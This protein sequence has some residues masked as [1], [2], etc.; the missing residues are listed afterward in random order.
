MRLA[1]AAASA[2][3]AASLAAPA[4]AGEGYWASILADMVSGPARTSEFRWQGRLASGRTFEIKGVNGSIQVAPGSGDQVELVATRRGRRNDPED[5]RIVAVEH[6]GGMTVCAVY[7]SSDGG[8]P[9]ECAP[10]DGGRMNVK[11]NDVNVDFTVKVPRGVEVVAR[12]VNGA[13]E[14]AGLT[15]DVDAETVNGSVRIETTGVARAETVNGSVN[16][17]M[18]RADWESDLEFKTVN[19]SIRVT[20]PASASTTVDAE[21]VNGSIETDFAVA[22]GKFAKRHLTGTIGSGGR[23]LTLE[24]VNGSITI[25]SR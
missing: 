17:V 23:G 2:V 22:G 12:T 18:G 15:A 7:P 24:T 14:A 11:N 5:V 20:L 10:G 1:A 4:S 3:L 16:A 6:A 21:V 13:V 25:A 9:N 19:G 8:R